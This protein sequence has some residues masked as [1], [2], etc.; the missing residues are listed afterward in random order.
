MYIFRIFNKKNYL[1]NEYKLIF[2]KN[3]YYE[4]EFY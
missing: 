1:F 2:N 4:L 3:T